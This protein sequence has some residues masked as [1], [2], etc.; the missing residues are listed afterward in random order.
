M[1]RF[2]E[3]PE[4]FPPV[5]TRYEGLECVNRSPMI[6]A[7]EETDVALTGGGAL[8]ASPTAAWNRGGDRAGELEP[9]AARGVPPESRM[10]VGRLGTATVETVR[11]TRVLIQGVRISGWQ[12][13]HV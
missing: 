6:Y 5:R 2:S 12:F 7:L 11:C 8:D 10:V 9:L 4:Q 13:G 1:V 3:A